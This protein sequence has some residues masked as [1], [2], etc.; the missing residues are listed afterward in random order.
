M[1]PTAM[2]PAHRPRK[3]RRRRLR[4][5]TLEDRRLLATVTVTSNADLVDGNVTSIPALLAFPGPVDPGISLREAIVAANNTLGADNILFAPGLSGATHTLSSIGQLVITDELTIDASNLSSF[6]IDAHQASRIL[7]L[8]DPGRTDED[9]GVTLRNLTLVNGQTTGTISNVLD[10][11]PHGGAI[12][13]LTGGEL[14][15]EQTEVL[16]SRTTGGGASGGGIFV[17]HGSVT[18]IESAISNNRTLGFGA[19]G[20]GLRIGGPGDDQAPFLTITRSELSNNSTTQDFSA[21]GGIDAWVGGETN[22]SNSIIS[23]NATS[24][25]TSNGGGMTITGPTPITISTSTIS[26]N[27]TTGY[28]STGGGL[29]LNVSSPAQISDST[30]ANNTTMGDGAQGGGIHISAGLTTITNS[31]I[32]GN[33]AEGTAVTEGPMGGGIFK[34]AQGIVIRNSTI[35]N[36]YS[37]D[38]GGGIGM[39]Q[40]LSPTSDYLTVRNSIVAEN[41]SGDFSP[42]IGY[43]LATSQLDVRS[44]LIGSNG[45]TLLVAT[46]PG[47]QDSDGNF[48]GS[49][50]NP[51]APGL[52]DLADNGGPTLTHALLPNS[53]G[54]DAGDQS[55]N[56]IEVTGDQRGAPFSRVIGSDVDMGAFES[57]ESLIAGGSLV[58]DSLGDDI[59]G[60]LSAGET[61]LREAVALSNGIS[62]SATIEFNIS[63]TNPLID[64]GEQLVVRSDV[65]IDGTNQNSFGGIVSL[66]GL[67]GDRLFDIDGGGNGIGG[68]SDSL[69]EVTLRDLDMSNGDP[70]LGTDGGAILNR[71]ADLL[72]ERAS[73]YNNLAEHGGAIRNFLG[74]TL[75]VI[76]STLS[77]NSATFG[78]AVS[79]FGTTTIINST[80]SSNQSDNHGGAL[81]NHDGAI[82]VRH[83][84]IVAN[85]VDAD[86]NGTGEGGGIW[87]FP[88]AQTSTTLHNTIVAGNLD[89]FVLSDFG[90]KNPESTSSYNLIGDAAST[91]GGFVDVIGGNRVGYFATDVFIDENSDN[92]ID[93]DDLVSNGGPTRTHALK[94]N[95]PAID[96]GDPNVSGAPDFDQRLAPFSRKIGSAIDIGAFESIEPLRPNGAWLVDTVEDLKDDDYSAGDFSLREA[97]HFANTFPGA[98]AIEFSLNASSTIVRNPSLGQ[99]LISS[100]VGIDG[101][102]RGA[103]GGSVILDGGGLV[104]IMGIEGVVGDG[105]GG[106]DDLEVEVN[107]DNLT[108]QNGFSGSGGAFFNNGGIVTLDT[109]SVQ[110][111]LAFD[112][113]GG[114]TNAAGGSL[115][116]D[117]STITGNTSQA[118]V[119]QHWGGGGIWN[120]GTLNLTNSTLSGNDTANHGGAIF[121]IQGSVVLSHT[122]VARNRANSDG[123]GSGVGGGIWTDNNSLTNTTL[124]HSIVSDNSVGTGS[125]AN[126]IANKDVDPTSIFNLI[127][128]A[129][130]AGGLTNGVL[131][132]IVGAN[133]KLGPLAENGGPTLTHALLPGSPAIDAGDPSFAAP[134]DFDQRGQFFGR[135]YGYAIDIGAV[136]FQEDLA[137]TEVVINNGDASRSMI[138]SLTIV[139]NQLMAHEGILDVDFV[140]TDIDA[141]VDLSS[142]VATPF[143]IGTQTFVELTFGADGPG[144][145][146]DE[147][148]GSGDLGH[149]LADGNYQLRVDSTFLVAAGGKQMTADHIF[150]GKT[151]VNETPY[152]PNNDNFFRHYGDDNGDGNTDFIDFSDGFL[153]SFG[154][155]VG[156]PNYDPTL[157]H[158][159][160]GNVDFIDFSN[161]FLPNFGTGRL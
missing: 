120:N 159:G 47:T 133:S 112:V 141:G 153:P 51:I 109:S 70:G 83:S 66:D 118:H 13:S 55:L 72:V 40:L 96:A 35:T 91:S 132:N 89:G 122:T 15:L 78:G 105:T 107:L 77:G 87:T 128:D 57:H 102:N 11:T 82:T 1:S 143:D 101:V 30:I 124:L 157:D 54:I 114:I 94:V 23:G 27:T 106:A 75:T 73:L 115:T 60:D 16:N 22:I 9:F 20:G 110:Y 36:N 145:Y 62:G 68:S 29:N 58:V 84:T 48:I 148:L 121:N 103:A 8:D 18:L 14:I 2:H 123:I 52:A 6:T 50:S 67:S 44:S 53:P 154:N 131:G 126:E 56:P 156:D 161:G 147:R 79:S 127:G 69:V 160:D 63:T 151:R 137:V 158:D 136:E 119:N 71:G 32:S 81:H 19:R 38:S 142:V 80:L 100:D 155:G 43:R 45:G 138:T 31:T 129:S 86:D 34:G 7:N 46:Q 149:S 39:G 98:D 26:D 12:R 111:N 135:Q 10:T 33:R 92:Q 76:D 125:T 88:D 116:I 5:E 61:T 74:G 90:G 65:V 42:D 97:I 95:S 108:F 134:P 37:A 59:D 99:L 130:T 139:F 146:V 152:S 3:S 93:N 21:G 150:G 117:S 144:G 49:T 104:Q 41:S 64:I 113:G 28:A 17:S 24:G 140:I 4:L 85:E 25:S